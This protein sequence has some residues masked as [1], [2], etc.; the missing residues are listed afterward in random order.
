MG[1]AQLTERMQVPS[2]TAEESNRAG[3]SSFRQTATANVRLDD[4]ENFGEHAT[5][6]VSAVPHASRPQTSPQGAEPVGAFRRLPRVW[7]LCQSKSTAGRERG[8]RR[9]FRTTIVQQ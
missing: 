6:R 2:T 5:W 4:N 1:L 3:T 7:L 9:R 8:L